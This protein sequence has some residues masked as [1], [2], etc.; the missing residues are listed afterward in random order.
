LNLD[1]PNNGWQKMYRYFLTVSTLALIAGTPALAGGD[2]ATSELL[3]APAVS[4]PNGKISVFGGGADGGSDEGG[5]IY[6]EGSFS[7]PVAHAFGLQVDG[8]VGSAGS[9]D[10]TLAQGAAHLFWRDPG[11]GLLGLYGS[12]LSVDSSDMYR[13][14][15]EG[16]LYLNRISLEGMIGWDEADDNSDTFWSGTLAYYPSENTRVFGGARHS[17]WRDGT[18]QGVGTVGFVGLEHQMNWGNDRRAYSLFGEARFGEN[19]YGAVWGGL[20][21]YFGQNKSLKRRHREDDPFTV[22]PD[23][24]EIFVGAGATP[25]QAPPPLEPK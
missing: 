10:D 23:L 5:L 15:G 20:R 1:R 21:V 12:A 19:D 11:K 8:L 18:I 3:S 13:I 4:A 14:A 25:P 6:G 22:I 17:E 16:Q 24:E 9:V 7:L 2:F